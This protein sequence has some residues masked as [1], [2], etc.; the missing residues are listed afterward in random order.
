ML[1]IILDKAIFEFFFRYHK[2]TKLDIQGLKK[3][4]VF[5]GSSRCIHHIDP[6]IV[7][8][9]CVTKSYNMGWAA[10]NPRE[11]YAAIKIY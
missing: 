1:G 5:F 3:E 10:S 6:S 7:D 11:I 9:I 4:I 8:S 2:R